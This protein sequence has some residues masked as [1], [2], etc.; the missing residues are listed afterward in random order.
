[1]G[2]LHYGDHHPVAMDDALLEHLAAV[3]TIRFRRTEPVLVTW[4]DSGD[5]TGTASTLWLTPAISC[6][7]VY[8]SPVLEGLDRA[9]MSDLLSEANTNAGIVLDDLE[10]LPRRR[11]SSESARV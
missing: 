3:I 5:S 11:R 6:R 9:L 1:M 8:D 7:F 4:R 10:H 2:A